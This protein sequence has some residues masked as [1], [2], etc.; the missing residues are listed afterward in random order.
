[1]TSGSPCF[2]SSGGRDL[3]SA[4][5]HTSFQTLWDRMASSGCLKW[6]GSPNPKHEVAAFDSATGML[7][8]L[9]RFAWRGR[10]AFGELPRGWEPVMSAVMGA[11]DR[12]PR[13]LAEKVYAASGW[14][15]AVPAAR[16]GQV[17]S[18]ALAE[19]IVGHYPR[20]RSTP[21]CSAR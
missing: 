1:M 3:L 8:A 5:F 20:R 6:W 7:R 11:A 19:W 15:E 4:S 10:P 13:R 14:T 18:A 21:W 2:W 12:L 9:S 17:S 16:T